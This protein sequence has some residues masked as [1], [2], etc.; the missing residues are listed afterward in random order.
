VTYG[1][2]KMKGK[3]FQ[4]VSWSEMGLGKE[5]FPFLQKVRSG[6]IFILPHYL[7]SDGFFVMAW[8]RE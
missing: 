3:E 8:K 1:F 4:R 6:G 5:G 2:E 7:G